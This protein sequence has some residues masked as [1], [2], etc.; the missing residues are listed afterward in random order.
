MKNTRDLFA[1]TDQQVSTLK[2]R[3]ARQ[4]EVIKQAKLRGH[5]TAAA[6]TI[7][8]TLH[9]TLRAFE[10]RRQQLFERLEPKREDRE[11]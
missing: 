2:Q 9:Q 11:R 10:K 1:Q 7:Q 8:D 4:R 6:E 3:I 5:S